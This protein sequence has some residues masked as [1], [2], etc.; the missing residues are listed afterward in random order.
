MFVSLTDIHEFHHLYNIGHIHMLH[1]LAKCMNIDNIMPMTLAEAPPAPGGIWCVLRLSWLFCVHEVLAVRSRL[2][3]ATSGAG[4]AM[5]VGACAT[6]PG[7]LVCLGGSLFFV[8]SFRVVCCP[9]LPHV[10]PP[11]Y[12]MSLAEGTSTALTQ[13]A[14]LSCG[15]AAVMKGLI[16]WGGWTYRG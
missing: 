4:S 15:A 7:G 10:L 11:W 3:F 8:L 9:R 6:N 5:Q 13:A 16:P 1:Q 2:R 14:R 12:F